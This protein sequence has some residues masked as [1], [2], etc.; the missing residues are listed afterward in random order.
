MSEVKNTPLDINSLATAIQYIAEHHQQKVPLQELTHGL[1]TIVNQWRLEQLEEMSNR[2]KLELKVKK[3]LFPQDSTAYPFIYL[4]NDTIPIVV[5]GKKKSNYLVVDFRYGKGV[6]E[7]KLTIENPGYCLFLRPQYQEPLVRRAAQK[8][9][10]WFFDVIKGDWPSLRNVL[11]VSLLL[12]I[13]AVLMPLY[14][15]NIYDRVVPNFAQETLWALSAGMILM[16]CWDYALRKLRSHAIDEM[17]A[18]ID[19]TISNRILNH[20]LDIRMDQRIESVG[21]LASNVRGFESVRDFITNATMTSLIDVPMGVFFLIAVLWINAWLVL[22]ILIG[23]FLLAI[24]VYAIQRRLHQLSETTYQASAQKNAQLIETLTHTEVIKT[25][26]AHHVVSD[27]W[28]RATRYLADIQIKTRGLS[29]GSSYLSASIQQTVNVCVVILGVYLIAEKQLTTGGLIA[30]TM[31][32]SRALSPMIQWIGLALQY[33][34]VKT[35]FEGLDKLMERQADTS[36]ETNYLDKT[37][38]EGKLSVKNMSFEYD[39][40]PTKTISGINLSLNPGEKIGIIGKIGSGKSTLGK[41]LASLY[42]PTQGSICIDDLDIRQLHPDTVRENILYVG[43]DAQLFTGSLRYNLTLSHRH[44]KDDV[45][46]KA[47]DVAGL[48]PLVQNHPR[49]LDMP[50]GE[51]GQALSGGQRQALS[52]ARAVLSKAKIIILDEPTSAMDVMSEKQMMDKL[53]TLFENRTLLMVT[54]RMNLLQ[55]TK[56]L[57]VIDQGQI[58]ADGPTAQVLQAI[59]NGQLRSAT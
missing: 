8:H 55:Y 34:G 11:W 13:F 59:Q 45:L 15:M 44:I 23:A 37:Q 57:I 54:H 19:T 18:R 42:V 40:A 43:Q 21:S 58:I 48:L 50:I 56:R 24:C 52:I 1:P 17:A 20:V 12:N 9:K 31:L 6:Q 7:V 32:A 2:A 46:L 27:A 29:S 26:N 35:A 53:S 4:L 14:S 33:Q 41:L 49:G 51:R 39:G 10:H 16:I 36:K 38:F 5:L 30:A 22:P 3:T 28:N 25:Y 47:C